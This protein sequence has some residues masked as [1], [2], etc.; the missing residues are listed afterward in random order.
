MVIAHLKKSVF[1]GLSGL[2]LT[3]EEKNWLLSPK[4]G[5]VILF[6]RNYATPFQLKKLTDSI[7]AQREDLLISVDHEGGRVQRFRKGFTTI[8]PMRDLGTLYEHNPNIALIQA[9]HYGLTIAKELKEVGVDFSYTPVCDLDYGVNPVIGDR[10]FHREPLVVARLACALYQ[11]LKEGGSLGVAKHFPGHGYCRVDTH[12]EKAVDYRSLETLM[13]ND[14]L[15]FKTLIEG[16]IE[17]IMPSHI[18]YPTLDKKRSALTSPRWLSFLREELGF[19]GAIISDDL[20]MKAFMDDTYSIQEKVAH[21]FKAGIN[22]ALLCNNFVN[23]R[24]YLAT[25]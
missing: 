17:A 22:I 7:K 14:I 16:G 1:I 5:G 18:I 10:A 19:K 6:R 11:G 23:I 13:E 12:L 3:T 25:S 24:D 20:D 21:C 2:S 8:P 9:K 15:P 4:V